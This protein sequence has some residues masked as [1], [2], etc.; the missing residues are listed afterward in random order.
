MVGFVYKTIFFCFCCISFLG[1]EA[2]TVLRLKKPLTYYTM[3]YGVVSTGTGYWLSSQVKGLSS[4]QVSAFSINQL[5]SF[6][7]SAAHQYSTGADMYS[8]VSAIS[9]A[10]LP[11]LLSLHKNVR[12]E[13]YVYNNV[14]AQAMLST[15]GQVLILKS[16]VKKER[17]F[18]YGVDAPM[19]DRIA[20]GARFSFPSG[21]TAIAATACFYGAVTYGLYFPK[22][23]YKPLVWAGA[24]VLPLITGYLRYKAGKHFVSD[25]AAGYAIGAAN[26][27][28]F[29]L[30]FKVG[31]R[32]SN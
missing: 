4:S 27:I 21:H 19:D 2:Q 9:T 14:Y 18:L 6:D 10:A 7:R 8:Y 5:S 22:S 23:K 16:L 1:T 13:F 28:I 25:I 17:P 29:P 15:V 11:T 20:S 32:R 24:V 31:N 30:V 26:G 3:A 12:A